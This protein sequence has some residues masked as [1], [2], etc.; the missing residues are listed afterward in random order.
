[1]NK[2][3]Q[4]AHRATVIEQQKQNQLSIKQFCQPNGISYQAS[5]YWS[6]RLRSP[7][8]TRCYCLSFS[9]SNL[10]LTRRPG[11]VVLVFTNGVLGPSYQPH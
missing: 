5:F 2:E 9:R 7:D 4:L 6:K 8:T 10:N 3:Q 1:M 11:T